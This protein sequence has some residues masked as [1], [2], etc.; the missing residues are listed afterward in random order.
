MNK[1]HICCFWGSILTLTLF[2]GC[3]KE[4]EFVTYDSGFFDIYINEGTDTIE[5]NPTVINN[6]SIESNT[7]IIDPFDNNCIEQII[8]GYDGYGDMTINCIS[9]IYDIRYTFEYNNGK[10][11][12]G[13][14]IGVTAKTDNNDIILSPSYGELVIEGLKPLSPFNPFDG[15]EIQ[16]DG[17]SPFVTLSYNT[18]G[19]T[20]IEN[21]E[22]IYISDKEFYKNG[23]SYSVSVICD[24]DSLGRQGYFI[25][26]SDVNGVIENVSEYIYSDENID[27]TQINQE[28][29]DYIEANAYASIGNSSILDCH[30]GSTIGEIAYAREL[31]EIYS[32]TPLQ[33]NL[34]VAKSPDK[35]SMINC[36][37]RVYKIDFKIAEWIN[38]WA[39][40]YKPSADSSVYAI[41][42]MEDIVKHTDGTLTYNTDKDISSTYLY[43]E[44]DIS[45]NELKANYITAKKSFCNVQEITS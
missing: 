45:L 30:V 2:S 29:D 18:A 9:P 34:F 36:Y 27:F 16:L 33:S 3:S 38:S 32:I 37:A 28:M 5:D 22:I 8:M 19:C 43:Y 40:S 21:T 10:L 15:L 39:N 11:S 14:V 44:A 1:K 41:V 24:N 7:E 23:Q 12:N 13:D 17:I 26:E 25:S 35:N 31:E 6:N 42:F 20:E 4:E